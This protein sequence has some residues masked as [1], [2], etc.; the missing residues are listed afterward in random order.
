[1][2]WLIF[3]L[4][5]IAVILN[6]VCRSYC[7]TRILQ[8]LKLGRQHSVKGCKGLGIHE[9]FCLFPLNPKPKQQCLSESRYAWNT[10]RNLEAFAICSKDSRHLLCV[11]ECFYEEYSTAANNHSLI[12]LRNLN[13]CTIIGKNGWSTENP[14]SLGYCVLSLCC[15][16][17][18]THMFLKFQEIVS[19]S[20][21]YQGWLN[22]ENF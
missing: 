17:Y 22:L 9:V 8:Y 21:R 1:M 18:N 12:I 16:G 3:G 4:D 7:H 5:L 10:G 15:F 20:H 14:M 2:F 6:R 13:N 19:A 11:D